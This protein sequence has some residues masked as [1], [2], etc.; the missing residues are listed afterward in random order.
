MS[1]QVPQSNT[2]CSIQIPQSQNYRSIVRTAISTTDPTLLK[3]AVE[4]QASQPRRKPGSEQ[5]FLIWALTQAIKSANPTIVTSL[6]DEHH[7]PLSSVTPSGLG[8][9][10][11]FLPSFRGVAGQSE[12]N[13][14][15][16]VMQQD[17]IKVLQILLDRGWNINQIEGS[18]DADGETILEDKEVT[19]VRRTTLLTELCFDKVLL[20]WCVTEGGALPARSGPDLLNEVVRK[21][22]VATFQFLHARNAVL[23]RRA[24]HNAVESAAFAIS[25][26]P[27]SDA[28]ELNQASNREARKVKEREAIVRYLVEE[29]NC[30]VSALDLEVGAKPVHGLRGTPLCFGINA[31][32]KGAGKMTRYLLSKGADPYIRDGWD[33]YDAFGLAEQGHNQGALEVL[34]E[35]EGEREK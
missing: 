10:A 29:L 17:F 33:I 23:G 15:E 2:N 22:T 21:G 30:D 9:A 3:Q 34:R 35:W 5:Q 12:A 28:L 11:Y 18:N 19:E 32:G 14:D 13:E 7:A 20:E 24:L 1:A 6:L 27:S 25:L 31:G 4:V 16:N 26:P 8:R